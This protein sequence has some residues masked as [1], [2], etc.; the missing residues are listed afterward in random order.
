MDIIEFILKRYNG[1]PCLYK[2]KVILHFPDFDY[3]DSLHNGYDITLLYVDYLEQGDKVFID[4]PKYFIDI[5]HNEIIIMK[6]D[7]YTVMQRIKESL[8]LVD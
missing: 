5:S 8:Y 7:Y 4:D 3:D 2:D 1:V 6:N